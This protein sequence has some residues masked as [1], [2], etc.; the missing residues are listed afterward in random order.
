MPFWPKVGEVGKPLLSLQRIPGWPQSERWGP[1]AWILA[2]WAAPADWPEFQKSAG[3]TP[4]RLLEG[5]QR[6]RANRRSGTERRAM[7][8]LGWLLLTAL[9]AQDEE[10]LRLQRALEGKTSECTALVEAHAVAQE[11]VTSQAERVQEL[12]RRCEVLVARVANKR[13][14]KLGRRPV[15]MAQVRAV[16]AA[17]FWDPAAWDGN[18]WDSSSSSEG[19]EAEPKLVVARARPVRELRAEECGTAR[20]TLSYSSEW[21]CSSWE[22]CLKIRRFGAASPER[23]GM[24]CSSERMVDDTATRST[25]RRGPGDGGW[26]DLHSVR[27]RGLSPNGFT[28][29]LITALLVRG[30]AAQGGV[31]PVN[32]WV[33]LAQSAVNAT[34]FCLPRV[35]AVGALM[36]TCFIGVCTDLAVLQQHSWLFAISKDLSYKELY[37]LGPGAAKYTLDASMYSF[38]LA[39]V[40]AAGTCVYFVNAWHVAVDHTN[41]EL[42]CRHKSEV[43][44]AYGHMKLPIGWFLLCGRTAFTYVPANSS[45]DPCA[46]GRVAPLLFPHPSGGAKGQYRYRRESIPLD[47]TCKAE[48]QDPSLLMT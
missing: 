15:T 14:L 8:E 17:P 21:S 1:V 10:V 24:A 20:G 18:I 9:R 44:F 3:I 23:Y 33:T 22:F 47:S 38:R 26:L 5:L 25:S 41:G 30:G 32:A 40:T 11:V 46:I 29:T 16:T 12:T 31:W 34:T 13:R 37:A 48:M 19:E 35:Y 4:E 43:S 2:G 7:G 45:G 6:L 28:I 39:N 36:E 27:R 42:L